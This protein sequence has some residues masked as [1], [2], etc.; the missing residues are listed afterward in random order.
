MLLLG[1]NRTAAADTFALIVGVNDCPS[2]RLP[3]GSRPRSLRGAETDAEQMA[4]LLIAQGALDKQHVQILLGKQAT[5]HAVKSAFLALIRQ[6]KPGDRFIF[7]FSGHGTQIPDRPP[8][9][10]PDGL[11]EALCVYDATAQGDNL[12]VDDELGQWLD[13]I[14]ARNI[15]VLLDCCHAGTGTKDPDDDIAARYLPAQAAG[16]PPKMAKEP[17]RDLRSSSKSLDKQITAFF[18]CAADQQAYERRMPQMKAPARVGQF[19]HYF[20]E[21]LKDARA[22]VNHDGVISNQESLDYAKS[23]LQETFNHARAQVRDRQEP[24]L[25]TAEPGKPIFGFAPK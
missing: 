22:D 23:R 24:T 19:T 25:E 3:D 6:L 16:F 13:E 17:W 12:V 8:L 18:A 11:D 15:T 9:D 14:P 4:E 20:L 10:E 21:G 2:F 7:Q 1:N 5:Y